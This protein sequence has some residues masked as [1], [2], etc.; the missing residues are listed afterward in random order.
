LIHANSDLFAVPDSLPPNRVCD[1]AIPL[2]P[3]AVPVNCR[4][5]SYSPHHKDE[6]EKQV[7]AM[8]KAGTVVPSLS[9]FASPVLLVKK[10]DGS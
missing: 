10:K 6:I 8:L 3:D 5:Y 9:P 2:Y 4:P 7:A 1:H